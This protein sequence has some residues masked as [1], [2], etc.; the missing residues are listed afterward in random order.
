MLGPA[1]PRKKFLFDAEDAIDNLLQNSDQ[2][3][4]DLL[5]WSYTEADSILRQNSGVV[6]DLTQRLI[7]GASTI[8]DCVSVLEE[9][10]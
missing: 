8:G 2:E 10:V 3:M 5:K 9:W 7:G 4:E 1:R 6:N